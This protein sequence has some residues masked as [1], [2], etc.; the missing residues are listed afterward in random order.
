M[1]RI[2]ALARVAH[3]HE[4]DKEG[5][6]G[7]RGGGSDSIDD[8]ASIRKIV[9]APLSECTEDRAWIESGEG[10]NSQNSMLRGPQSRGG[11]LPTFQK[12]VAD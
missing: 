2:N 3:A 6:E 7:R 4:E 5:R 9:I 1:G 10:G 8:L 12:Q 11:V